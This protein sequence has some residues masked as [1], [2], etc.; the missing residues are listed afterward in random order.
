MDLSITEMLHR[1]VDTMIPKHAYFWRRMQCMSH[2]YQY[3]GCSYVIHTKCNDC[4]FFTF[5]VNKCKHPDIAHTDWSSTHFASHT[6][7]NFKFACLPGY[8][9]TV[10]EGEMKC[11]ESGTIL[12]P[13]ECQGRLTKTGTHFKIRSGHNI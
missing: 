12:D 9:A 13:P 7:M 10:T 2:K 11:D 3:T 4:H 5:S 1:I 6:G 8:I